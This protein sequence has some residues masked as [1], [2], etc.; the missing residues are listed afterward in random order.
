MPKE[1]DRSVTRTEEKR[2]IKRSC[3]TDSST[4]DVCESGM[5]LVG[6]GMPSESERKSAPTSRVWDSCREI[7]SKGTWMLLKSTSMNGLTFRAVVVVDDDDADG[8]NEGRGN[9]V[10]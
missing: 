5:A 10:C 4:W 1:V 8:D 9:I 3:P 6:G 7:S 2:K